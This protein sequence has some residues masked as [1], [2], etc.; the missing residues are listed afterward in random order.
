MGRGLIDWSWGGK[1]GNA[2]LSLTLDVEL[3]LV[4]HG[5]VG[6]LCVLRPAGQRPALV[7]VRGPELEDGPRDVPV[8]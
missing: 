3:P 2:M 7:V 1:S 8:G 6:D 4:L 5:G